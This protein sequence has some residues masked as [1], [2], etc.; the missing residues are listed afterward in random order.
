MAPTAD[1]IL[2]TLDAL[3][4]LGDL[5]RTGWLL[6]GISPCES[7]AS[8]S[9]AVSLLVA[10]LVDACRAEG[11]TVDGEAA[12]RMALVHDAP[13]AKLGDVP[14]PV[15]T[16][17]LDAALHVVEERLAAELLPPALKAAWSDAEAGASLEAKL[18]KAADK[19]QMLHKLSVYERAGRK[20]PLIEFMW[21]NPANLKF[22]ELAPVRRLYETIFARAG[23]P[24]PMPAPR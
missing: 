21:Q 3:D 8:H 16:T 17:E 24:M 12:L 7:I 2:D 4:P 1:V 11:M 6:R 19:L 15:K 20:H 14:M 10:M 13:E 5:P 9:L 23:R 18:V 22:L